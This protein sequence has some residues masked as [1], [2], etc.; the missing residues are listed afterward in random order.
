MK[1]IIIIL[2]LLL[3][4]PATAQMKSATLTASGLTCSMCSK[5]IFKA[6]EKVSFIENVDADVEKSTFT[7]RFKEGKNVVLDDVKKAVEHA[8]FSVASMAV[9]ANFSGEEVY[10]DACIN[11]HGTSLHFLN[12]PKQTLSGTK[13]FTVVD[14]NFLP[15]SAYKKYAKYTQKK[16]FETGMMA[17]CCPKDKLTSNRIYHVTL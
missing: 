14:K 2:L 5:S 16:C 12:V 17:D 13:T 1:N 15:A 3:Q 7:V 9:T 8:G 11:L 10:N 4:L 6:L